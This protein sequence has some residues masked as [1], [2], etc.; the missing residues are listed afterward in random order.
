MC[1]FCVSRLF[2]I[3]CS[4]IFKAPIT[5]AADDILNWASAWQSLQND[6]CAQRRLRSDWAESSLSAWRKF[7]SLVTNLAH[8]KYS[9]Q[10]RRMPM[11]MLNIR[12]P[13][14][15]ICQFRHALAQLTVFFFVF[16][17]FCFFFLSYENKA[18]IARRRVGI[19]LYEG[20]AS[21]K[22]TY[23]ILTPLNPTFI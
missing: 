12:W 1:L 2:F 11:L 5:L 6:M 19:R 4:R 21:R 7:G 20:A 13:H 22:H 15:P 8:S 3:V 18:L 17:L 10:I 9:D 23:I 16:V 14:L